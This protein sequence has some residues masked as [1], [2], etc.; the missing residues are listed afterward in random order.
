MDQG[1]GAGGG[2]RAVSRGRNSAAEGGLRAWRSEGNEARPAQGAWTAGEG[3]CSDSSGRFPARTGPV[4]FF[5]GPDEPLYGSG[6]ILIRLKVAQN[7]QL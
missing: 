1:S 5:L 7:K 2:R 4:P 6:K 3:L